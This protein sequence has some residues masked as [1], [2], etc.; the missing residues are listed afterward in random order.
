MAE[1]L[2]QLH[3]LTRD[4]ITTLETMEN[5]LKVTRAEVQALP[6]FVRGAVDKDISNATGRGFSDWITHAGRLRAALATLLTDGD[7][8]QYTTVAQ[9]ISAEEPKLS[10]LRGY[11]HSAPDRLKGAPA[12]ILKPQRKLELIQQL[13]QQSSGLQTL[14]AQLAGIGSMLLQMP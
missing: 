4:C 3:S 14:E 8:A 10:A 5:R 6:F 13:E 12:A 7:H 9:T 2:D 1:Q 11:L